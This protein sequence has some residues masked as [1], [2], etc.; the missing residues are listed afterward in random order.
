MEFM[1]TV[2][3]KASNFAEKHK[4]T[5]E[6]VDQVREQVLESVEDVINFVKTAD[7]YE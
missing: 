6:Q 5:K 1:S 2:N 3:T 7:G 4:Y